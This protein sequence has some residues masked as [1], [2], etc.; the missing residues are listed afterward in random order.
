M[1]IKLT[2][3]SADFK[4]KPV[5]LNT[6]YMLSFFENTVE[7]VVVTTAYSNTKEAW[8]VSETPDEILELIRLAKA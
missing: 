1:I 6:D 4:G 2:N 8:N 3:A 7:G 5:L